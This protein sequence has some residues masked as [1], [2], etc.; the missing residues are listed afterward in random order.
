[1]TIEIDVHGNVTWNFYR[2]SYKKSR[3]RKVGQRQ[4]NYMQKHFSNYSSCLIVVI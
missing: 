2:K 4:L 1:M 3:W